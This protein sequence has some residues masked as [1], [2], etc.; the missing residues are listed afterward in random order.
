[1]LSDL[2]YALRTLARNPGFAAITIL[3]LALGIGA[4]TAMFSVV[5]AV[6][7]KPLPF[8]SPDRLVYLTGKFAGGDQAGVSPPDYMDYSTANHTFEQ[9][10]VL[11]YAPSLAN[12]SG[13][14][15][16][17][18]VRN[19]IASWNLFAAVGI[20]PIL[21]RAFVP[22]DEQV[23]EPQAAVLGNGLWR[24]HF[25][26]DAHIVGKSIEL[27]GRSLTV[28]G[29][30]SS[31]PTV[32]SKTQIWLPLPLLNRGMNVRVAH[33]LVGV[34]KLA[35]GV[36]LERAQK[37]L[38]ADAAV[39]D[40]ANPESNKGWGIKIRPLADVLVGSVEK[41][42]VLM[43]AAVALLLVIA[44]ANVAN[45]LLS[46]GETRQR[47]LAVRRALGASRG[48]VVR[49]LLTESA[50]FA[51]GG[52]I[53]G[54]LAA[55]WGLALLRA[56]APSDLPRL[57]EIGVS[58]TPLVFTTGISILSAIF[59]GLAPALRSSRGR[60]GDALV[61][62]GR[63]VIHGRSR[64]GS[65]LVVGQIAISLV[66]LVGG[67]LLVESFWRLVSVRPGFQ[68]QHVVTAQL[69]LPDHPY[70]SPTRIGAFI[71][72]LEQRVGALPGV[73]AAGAI[74]ELPLAGEYGDNAF[75]ID[76]RTYAPSQSEDAQFRQVTPG[77]L[78]AMGIPL[79]AGR[80]VSWSDDEHTPQVI[81]VDE[82]FAEQYFGNESPIGKRLD[83][84]APGSSSAFT[85]AA[86]IVGVVGAVHQQG[87][88]VP[89]PAQMYAPVSQS[90]YGGLHIVLRTPMNTASA[91]LALERAV[92]QLDKNLAISSVQTMQDVLASSVQ[93][94]R[95]LAVL[96]TLFAAFAVTI[97]AVGL[98]GLVAYTVSQRTKDLGIRMALGAQ[99]GAML[100]LVLRGGMTLAIVGAAVGLV[101]ALS[102]GRYLQSVLFDIR[103]TDL[104]TLGSVSV[105]LLGVSFVACYIP[106]RRATK[107]DPIVSLRAD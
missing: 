64:L 45:L 18:Q 23:A 1:M 38:D 24:T 3:T 63:G 67:G 78:K 37:D 89:R 106:A 102:L 4:S 48:R 88:G 104:A 65:A 83:F 77:Y 31:D 71:H 44:C 19:A 17:E 47:E 10:A 29:V 22:A 73:E 90:S 62:T 76:G 97:A 56:A 74:S 30:L 94:P 68:P 9:M 99:R 58:G 54:L 5:D 60:F 61:R 11:S 6:L 8:G 43:S 42:L 98:Y 59:F 27:D 15:K 82:R 13:S 14:G 21:G 35:P 103:P 87:L 100:R 81:V 50:V 26:S 32:L 105:L 2:R 69:N 39:I 46:R 49:L 25:G 96:L 70:D 57:N 53:V 79:L 16:P 40:E 52:G 85:S 84:L 12:L 41:Q 66:L 95:F 20:H 36:T 33:F 55:V 92:N 80:W 86:T 107:V 7:L 91:M 101:I 93:Q 75:Q 34:G 51:L 28:V 72:Q